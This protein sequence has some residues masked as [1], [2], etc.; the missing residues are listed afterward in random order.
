MTVTREK[1]EEIFNSP[2]STKDFKKVKGVDTKTASGIVEISEISE[3]KR[4]IHK[5]IFIKFRY[6][7]KL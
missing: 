3:I 2:L 6:R 1:L 4:I 5:V 7:K